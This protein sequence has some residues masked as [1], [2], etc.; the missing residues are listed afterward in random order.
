MGYE[1]IKKEFRSPDYGIMMKELRE[2]YQERGKNLDE[3]LE[4]AGQHFKKSLEEMHKSPKILTEE[5]LN[6][7][8]KQEI[9]FDKEWTMSVEWRRNLLID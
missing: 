5:E 6:A 7:I 3:T 9:E 2:Y 4:R 8:I 1:E